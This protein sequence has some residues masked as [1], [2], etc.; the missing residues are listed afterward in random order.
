MHKQHDPRM[1]H[2]MDEEELK[3]NFAPK[4][5]DGLVL[6]PTEV[7]ELDVSERIEHAVDMTMPQHFMAVGCDVNFVGSSDLTPAD[8]A[9]VVHDD[10]SDDAHLEVADSHLFID[11][12]TIC[13]WLDSAEFTIGLQVKKWWAGLVAC[14][15]DGVDALKSGD[16]ETTV[17]LYRRIVSSLEYDG[18]TRT[19]GGGGAEQAG[20][21]RVQESTGCAGVATTSERRGVKEAI[22]TV[23]A[24]VEWLQ[25]RMGKGFGLNTDSEIVLEDVI[26]DLETVRST[27]P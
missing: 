17:D 16:D 9:G 4:V 15:E 22:L 27:L 11:E 6:K 7:E 25:A 24:L 23:S 13:L 2:M 19:C 12:E 21:D 26:H 3:L 1:F 10:D 18:H 5:K 14:E 20:K 8:G